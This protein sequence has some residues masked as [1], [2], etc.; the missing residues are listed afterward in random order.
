M[1]Q[2]GTYEFRASEIIRDECGVSPSSDALWAGTMVIAGDLVRFQMDDRL[3][4]IELLGYFLANVEKFTL[5]GSAGNVTTVANGA[6][7]LLTLVQ[8]HLDSVSDSQRAFHGTAGVKYKSGQT[9]C[10]C[11]LWARYSAS[12]R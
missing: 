6:E 3:F 7:C 2:E 11:E 12:L 8:A 5:D 10:T 9:G 1:Q 4:G